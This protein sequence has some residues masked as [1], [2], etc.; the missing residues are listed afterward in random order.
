[1]QFLG[2]MTP[3]DYLEKCDWAAPAFWYLGFGALM[4]LLTVVD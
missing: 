2:Y 1:M 3:V 4:G